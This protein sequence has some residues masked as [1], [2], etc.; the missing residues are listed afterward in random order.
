M[1]GG[2]IFNRPSFII[3]DSPYFKV[4]NVP[5]S[6]RL[7]KVNDYILENYEFFKMINN[8]KILKVKN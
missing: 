3:Y 6:E 4:D 5:M 1:T 8:Y 2:Q 7:A